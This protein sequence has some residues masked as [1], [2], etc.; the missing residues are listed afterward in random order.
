MSYVSTQQMRQSASIL[1]CQYCGCAISSGS[2]CYDCE[3]RHIMSPDAEESLFIEIDYDFDG[4]GQVCRWMSEDEDFDG[5][6]QVGY[7]MSEDE[8]FG[9]NQAMYL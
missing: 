6:D 4:F 8:D 9:W 7:W 1:S 5:F 2:H 3:D